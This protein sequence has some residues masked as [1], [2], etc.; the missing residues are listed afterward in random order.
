MRLV[1]WA[2]AVVIAL[3][4]GKAVGAAAPAPVA[5]PKVEKALIAAGYPARSQCGITIVPPPRLGSGSHAFAG[6]DVSTCWVVVER[7]GYSVHVTPYTSA[8]LAKLAYERTRN[9]AATTTRRA[10]I[11]SVLLSAYRLPALEWSRIST[12]VASALK[13]RHS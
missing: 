2:A 9:P 3:L 11:G 10:A 5:A 1:V 12:I 8:A 7:H 4:P 6:H 13:A